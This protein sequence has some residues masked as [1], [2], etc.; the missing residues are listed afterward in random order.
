MC[1]ICKAY[2]QGYF[3]QRGRTGHHQVAG[4]LKTSSHY[5]GMWRLANS[6]FELTRE[7]CRAPARDSAEI[8]DV[9]GALQI[10]VYV[11]AY[12]KDLPGRQAAP[13]G[14]V[15]AGTTFDLGLQ[16]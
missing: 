9:N 5:V 6:H 15:G 1:L 3:T 4:F 14:T 12:S 16:D 10:I 7:V 11:S 8:A 2:A 13:Y